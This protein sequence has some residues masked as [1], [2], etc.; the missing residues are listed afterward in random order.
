MKY[1]MSD[2]HGCSDKYQ[3]MLELINFNNDDTLYILGDVI[4]RG[5]DGIKV[6]SDIMKREN[7]VFIMG[8]H[9]YMAM[10]CLP[11]LLDDPS[12]ARIQDMDFDDIM[13][14]QLWISNKC[15]PTIKELDAKTKYE[16]IAVY[17]FLKKAKYYEEVKAGENTFVL[18]HG[19]VD[20]Y[21][22]LNSLDECDPKCFL[23]GRPDEN[24]INSGDKFFVFGHTPVQL[25]S[26][27]NKILY[28]DNLIDIDC[29]CVFKGGRLG[30][31]CL[32]TLEEFYVC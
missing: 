1:V 24:P 14:L 6:L 19:V 20:N 15:G 3:K 21:A 9:E 16:R 23:Y 5:K 25:L 4:D 17:K 31:L 27:D 32:D 2:I 13:N 28:K 10:Q 30:C 29:G 7:M 11:F 18:S 26:K 22:L 12:N 8:N